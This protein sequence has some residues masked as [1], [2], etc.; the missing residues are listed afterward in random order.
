M[1]RCDDKVYFAILENFN[2]IFENTANQYQNRP[3][4]LVLP[5]L[6]F[7]FFSV[8]SNDLN[9]VFETSYL[10]SQVL[11]STLSIKLV[12]NILRNYH[13]ISKFD[14]FS[15]TFI[16]F[17]NPVIQFGTFSASNGTLSFLVLVISVYLLDKYKYKDYP[18]SIYLILGLLFLANRSFILI[19]GALFFYKIIE[20][21]KNINY[22]L[23]NFFGLI[24]FFIPNFLYKLYIRLSGYEVYD[25]NAEYYG[26]FI[27]ISKYFDQGLLFW[28][29]KIVLSRELFELRLTTNWNSEDEWYC[30]NIPENFICYFDDLLSVSN[31]LIIGIILLFLNLVT[32]KLRM[33]KNIKTNLITV[34]LTNMIFWSFIGWYPPLRFGL[35]SFGNFIFL[36]LIFNLPR[37]YRFEQKLTYLIVIIFSYLNIVHW[38]N[39]ELFIFNFFT[40]L[41]LILVLVNTIQ[42]IKSKPEL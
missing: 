31:Y 12:V 29:S 21:L 20:N 6:I 25:I 30:Q 37:Q 2:S 41:G 36:L 15:I 23:R 17:L 1:S 18:F 39:P 35:F 16:Y 9:F 24:L 14:I 27:W 34:G 19:L 26:Q 8:I 32:N 7:N 42:H 13:Y 10:I 28:T 22:Y 33:P 11:I 5:F 38:N 40:A 4:F 3:V